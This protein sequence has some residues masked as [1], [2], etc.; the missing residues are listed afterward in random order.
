MFKTWQC[1][2]I[3]FYLPSVSEFTRDFAKSKT[4]AFPFQSSHFL[5]GLGHITSQL[6]LI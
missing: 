4:P 3:G 1:V 6:P 5:Y 2:S